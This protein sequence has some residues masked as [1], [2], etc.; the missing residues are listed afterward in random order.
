[1]ERYLARLLD[2]RGSTKDFYRFDCLKAETVEKH[3]RKMMR[4]D[5]TGLITLIRKNWIERGVVECEIYS[6]ANGAYVAV[7]RFSMD[8]TV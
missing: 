4:K 7:R 2:E 5:N 3:I 6:S 1:M 8:W